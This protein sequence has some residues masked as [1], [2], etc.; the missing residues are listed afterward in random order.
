MHNASSGTMVSMVV[1]H[2]G[3]AVLEPWHH[4]TRVLVDP[5]T[6]YPDPELD[7]TAGRFRI[8]L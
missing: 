4:P 6:I 2:D 8:R 7:P 1:E 3:M 5:G